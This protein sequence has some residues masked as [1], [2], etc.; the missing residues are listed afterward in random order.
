[1]TVEKPDYI[2]D[3]RSGTEAPPPRKPGGQKGRRPSRLSGFAPA[4]L[5]LP[6]LIIA[7]IT[8]V[9]T[10]VGGGETEPSSPSPTVTDT[11]TISAFPTATPT[12]TAPPM[13][14]INPEEFDEQLVQAEALAYQSKFDEAIAV[15]RELVLQAPA[16]PRPERGWAWALLLSDQANEALSHAHRAVELDPLN[17]EATAVLARTYSQT[18]DKSRALGM[19][20]NAVQLDR[21]S[22]MAQVALA[23]AT[24][25]LG[26]EQEA[27]DA[28]NL[29]LGLDGDSAE[30]HR[31]RGWL[32]EQVDGDLEAALREYQIAADLQPALWLR[33]AELGE[34][35][36]K[37]QNYP[38]AITALTRALALRPKAGIYAA[39][40]EAH[41]HLGEYAQARA[42][43]LE[44]LSAGA[45]GADTHALLS[46]VEA[47]EGRCSDALVQFEQALAQAPNHKLA[48]EAREICFGSSSSPTPVPSQTTT[49][50]PGTALAPLRGRIAFPVW[51]TEMG[52]YDTY[53]ANADGSD[54]HLVVEEMHQPAFSP[55]G[56]WLAVNGDR[57]DHMNLFIVRPDGSDL[58]EITEHLEDSL[59]CWSPDG[60]SL[61]F[62]ST[63]HA[64]RRARLY[65]LDEVL[66]S[67]EKQQGRVLN[68][69]LYELLGE[70]PAWSQD[71]QIIY[72]ACDY[73]SVPPQ[74]GLFSIPADPGPQIPQLLT[75]H[76]G[77]T[78]PAAD[79][80]RIAFMSDR[81]GNWEIYVMNRDGSGLARLTDNQANDG[82]PTWSPDGKTLAFVSDRGGAWAVWAMSPDG[83]QRR[84]LFDVGGGG[85]GAG[86]QQQRIGWG[87]P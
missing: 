36:I 3:E 57:P 48:L 17:A 46:L 60:Q 29:A 87:P 18:G 69:S 77:D 71:G 1:M 35:L 40:G 47:R 42:S 32:Y 30:A 2:P 67:G 8:Y 9:V 58:V 49:P 12:A 86:W 64:D 41:Y 62:S 20:Q 10:T 28:A 45:G 68:S 44:A 11:V 5:I 7:L 74:C 66:F 25:R 61:V 37:T 13:T 24:L 54:R 39:L 63:R 27:V 79:G 33:Q 15:Y 4:A 81:D 19:A 22:A 73:T 80:D 59:P 14:P 6:L 65:I 31:I 82:L 34:I 52:Q 21:N 85:L 56:Q 51:D 55:D 84:K 23:E 43:L 26:L 50:T 75:T 70:Y 72:R 53:V 78:A 38:E 16:D 83:S 76:P